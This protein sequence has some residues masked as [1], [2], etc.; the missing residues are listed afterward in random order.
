M[1][2]RKSLVRR[3]IWT[4][5]LAWGGSIAA[6]SILYDQYAG[7]LLDELTGER[8]NAQLTAT[9]NRLSAFLDAQTHQIETLSNYPGLPNFAETDAETSNEEVAGLLRIEADSPDLY[10]ILFLTPKGEIETVL[11]GQAA[12][13]PPYSGA[14]LD[15]TGLPIT[16]VGDIDILGPAPPGDGLSGWFLIRQTLR[17]RRNGQPAGSIALHVRLA[18]LTEQLGGGGS[19]AIVEPLLATPAGYF[20]TVGHPVE[21]QGEL[22]LGP[23]LLPGWRPLLQMRPGEELLRPLHNARYGQ[24]AAVVVSAL[25]VLALFWRLGRKLKER[26]EP[27]VQGAEAI[28]QGDFQCRV[29]VKGDDEISVLARSFNSMSGRLEALMTQAVLMERM[30]TLGRFASAVAHEI[31]NP[32]ATMKTTVQAL[33]RTDADPEFKSLM[34]DMDG[35]IDRLARVTQDLLDFG[36]PRQP[37]IA[38]VM[39][40]DLFRRLQRLGEPMAARH[41][42]SLNLQGQANLAISADADQV[43][44]VLLNLVLNAL[45]ATREGGLVAVR[46]QRQDVATVIE[47]SDTGCG[48]PPDQLSQ[49][50]EPFYS[51][52]PTG[53]GLGLSICTQL[54]DLNR[55]TMTIDST[56][57][58]G[59]TVCLSFSEALL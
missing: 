34:V 8:L 30:A 38:R 20:D 47:I 11:A 44:Q 24:A 31:R 26:I 36:R 2:L 27:L 29:A 19:N 18:S 55:G 42:V 7:K 28:S 48:I 17:D 35:E 1:H 5:L 45:Q 52:K 4:I 3:Y 43:F 58:V 10:G 32:L 22:I 14:R 41:G 33:I 21:P 51:T 12:S 37:E 50:T 56:V 40:E 49:V 59:T 57:G 15:L 6:V 9:T 23:E 39:I 13:G 16:T 54:M 53:S 25:V 46:A